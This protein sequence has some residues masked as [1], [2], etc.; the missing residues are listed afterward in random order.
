MALTGRG[1]AGEVLR[2]RV[3]LA[4]SA[5]RPPRW[6]EGVVIEAFAPERAPELHAL[7][8]RGYRDGGGEV[9]PYEAW[10]ARM[11]GDPEFAPELWFLARA[12]GAP[13]GAAL[14]WTSAFVKDLVVDGAWRR[15]GLG[16][17]L[18]RRAFAEFSA[19]GHVAV[20]LKVHAENAPAVRL[21]ERVGMRVAE[22]LTPG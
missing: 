3:E 10:R 20:E 7:L 21:Y 1:G 2:M 8:T 11:T 15:R 6:P 18:L 14:C 19:R 13:V 22:R 17:A 5:L 4:P 9:A 12:G 16:E